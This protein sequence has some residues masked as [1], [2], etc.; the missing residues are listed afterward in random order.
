MKKTIAVI[1]ALVAVLAAAMAL[2]VDASAIALF[3]QHEYFETVVPV[4]CTEDGSVVFTCECGDTYTELGDPATGHEYVTEVVA[5]TCT[6]DGYNNNVCFC[7]SCYKDEYVDALGHD[8]S[9]WEITTMPTAEANGTETRVCNTCNAEE[10]R[11]YVCEHSETTDVVVVAASC[12]HGGSVNVICDVCTAI[13]AQYETSAT[14]HE[15]GSWKTVVAAAPNKVGERSRSCA[16]GKT[17]TEAVEFKMAGKNSIYIASAGINVKYVVAPFTQ[18]A[19]DANDVICNYT[20]LNQNNPIV[21]GHNTGS[22][23]KLYNAKIGSY[24]YFNV[25]GVTSTYKIKV[26][27]RAVETENCTE[28]KGLETGYELLDSYEGNTI[29]LY[30]CY[31]D[32]EYGKIRWIVMAE[33]VS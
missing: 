19:V 20:R 6:D 15:Y 4:T 2:N 12:Q 7:G 17:Q 25:D 33:K 18:A 10:T 9:D 1:I 26:S 21:L 29:R 14:D 32:K 28:L 31:Q 16:C 30:T 13:V 5:P 3:H 23:K 11:E 8:F 27:E 22:L 24:I